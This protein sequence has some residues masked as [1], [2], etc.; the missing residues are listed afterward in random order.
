MYG[1]IY[2][3]HNCPKED[4]MVPWAIWQLNILR[5][6]FPIVLKF[7]ACFDKQ[8]VEKIQIWIV[9]HCNLPYARQEMNV[10]IQS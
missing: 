4:E 3:E 6:N 5:D 2:V 9:G 8:W 7:W 10:A 1:A